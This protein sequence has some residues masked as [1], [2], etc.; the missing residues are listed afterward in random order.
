METL[1]ALIL[2]TA[3]DRL[4]RSGWVQAGVPQPE[5]IA[6]HIVG[7]ALLVLAL[8][9]KVAPKLDLERSV[10]LA[11]VHDAGE[12]LTTDLPKPA[13]E[14]LPPGAKAQAEAKATEL[15]LGSLSETAAARGAEALAHTTREARFVH[16]CDR[17]QLGVQLAAYVR[18]GLRGLEDFRASL[19]NLDCSEFEP[20][21]KLRGELLARCI[22]TGLNS[23]SPNSEVEAT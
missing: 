1:D 7:T 4:P 17:L 8:G 16:I 20:C 18:V 2:L 15:L 23:D 11:L 10:T 5:T 3:L 21:E 9:P 19:R 13:S 12:A 14:L 6:G 22:G